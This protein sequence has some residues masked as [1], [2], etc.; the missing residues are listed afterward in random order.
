MDRTPLRFNL[1]EPDQIALTVLATVVSANS[2]YFIID[3][4]SKTLSSDRGGHGIV[5]M[6]GYGLAYPVDRFQDKHSMILTPYAYKDYLNLSDRLAIRG[7]TPAWE[8]IM[9]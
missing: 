2:D 4:G 3:A 6:E 8:G 7:P 9:A 1:I 5:G